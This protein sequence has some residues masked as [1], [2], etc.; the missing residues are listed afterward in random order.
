MKKTIITLTLLFCA[1]LSFAQDLT[2]KS[3]IL[4]EMNLEARVGGG[5]TDLNGKQCALI[6]VMV[7]DNILKCKGGN[8]GDIIT[9]GVVK[10]IFVS[11]STKFLELEFQYN[12]PLKVTFSDYGIKNLVEGATYTITLVDASQLAIDQLMKSQQG[13]DVVSQGALGDK[14]SS[15]NVPNAN[16]KDFIT[17]G[18]DNVTNGYEYV[19]LGLSVNWATKN[20]GAVSPTDYGDYYAWGE[21]DTKSEYHPTECKTCKKK[22]ITDIKAN[23]EYDVAIVRWGNGWRLPSS[24]EFDELCKQCEWKWVSIGGHNGYIVTSKNGNSIFLPAAGWRDESSPMDEGKSGHYWSATPNETDPNYA[25]D[26]FFNKSKYDTYWSMRGYGRTIRPVTE[27]RE[28]QQLP[29]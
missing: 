13:T 26:L 25:S 1:T 10:K 18:S 24:E 4:N 7:R 11:P 28:S 29:H 20:I 16:L 19:D 5:R 17:I 15:T 2:V 9:E 14:G 6:K 23:M 22:K 27:Q 8:I 12:F 3:F 21:I